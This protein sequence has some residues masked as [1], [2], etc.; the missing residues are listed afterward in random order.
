[1]PALL[2]GS[3]HCRR[4]SGLL[5]VAA[6]AASVAAASWGPAAA[7]GGGGSSKLVLNSSH[8]I[9][10]FCAPQGGG[11][12]DDVPYNLLDEQELAG[13]PLAGGGGVPKTNWNPGYVKWYYPEIFAVVDLGAPHT[14][15][16]ICGY[17]QYGG[18]N[19]ELAF[20]TERITRP[21]LTLPVCTAKGPACPSPTLHWEKSW[22]CFNVTS[23]TA[24]F[25]SI[26]M[27]SPTNIYE[28]VIYGAPAVATT[29]AG[30]GGGGGG[31]GQSRARRD[32]PRRRPPL[33]RSFLG[34][35]GFVD[36]PV[37]R[38]AAV[39]GAVREYQD[40]GWTEGPGD[41]GFPHALNK[42][43]PSYS[44]FEID[45]FY[46]RAANASLDVHQVIQNRPWF[47]ARG[48]K[49]EVEW[50]PVVDAQIHNL[51]AIVDPSSYAG[52]AAHVY[53]VAARYGSVPVPSAS[54]LQLAPGQAPLSGLGILKHIE[55][56]KWVPRY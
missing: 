18:A 28:L 15:E 25:V 22:A 21:S 7:V 39:A 1:M 26:R 46:R 13:D 31:G 34:V 36:D 11:Y 9:D 16:H 43:E 56:L 37:E 42:F 49:S 12:E 32:R 5:N 53:Q 8:V 38:L 55:I 4:H 23:V 33:M 10:G 50:K 19:V 20:A 30:S 14:L 24:R 44:A 45:S 2:G 54:V 48:N 17:H 40:W 51:S 27:N 35:N 6:C 47:L 29:R 41:P 52:I 3:N